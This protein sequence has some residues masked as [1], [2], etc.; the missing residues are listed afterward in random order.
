VQAIGAKFSQEPFSKSV[1]IEW[2]DG[3]KFEAGGGRSDMM[4]N[5]VGVVGV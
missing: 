3:V 4:L 1:L 2:V 5:W